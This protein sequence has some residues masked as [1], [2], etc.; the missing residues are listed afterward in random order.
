MKHYQ[1]ITEANF[2]NYFSS[3]SLTS[4]T[5][6]NCFS[7][8]KIEQNSHLV[9]S[10]WQT[11]SN[12]LGR[13]VYLA[14]SPDTWTRSTFWI[15]KRSKRQFSHEDFIADIF[16]EGSAQNVNNS[17]RHGWSSRRK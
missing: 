4:P 9:F 3:N 5:V 2:L 14:G 10:S 16:T 1:H 8:C 6:L 12:V 11:S 7:H 17:L 13:E 15:T